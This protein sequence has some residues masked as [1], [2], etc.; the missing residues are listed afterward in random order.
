MNRSELI[1]WVR[2]MS[3]REL[4][5]Q[6]ARLSRSGLGI[7]T[8]A[9]GEIGMMANGISYTALTHSDW[10]EIDHGWWKSNGEVHLPRGKHYVYSVLHHSLGTID[11]LIKPITSNHE[12]M[13]QL[14]NQ[15][16]AEGCTVELFSYR[17][18]DH[19]CVI[20]VVELDES[21]VHHACQEDIEGGSPQ[22]AVGRA[23]VLWEISQQKIP[24]VAETA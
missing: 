8:P 4:S 18:D 19:H 17:P 2:G 16:L 20:G 15:L 22:E 3:A 13:W 12:V 14:W 5:L 9:P 23:F 24:F 1:N 7:G 21:D 10:D 6:A 11:I